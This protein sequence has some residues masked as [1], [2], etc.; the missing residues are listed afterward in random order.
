MISA[1]AEA[2]LRQRFE[3][4]LPHRLERIRNLKYQRIIGAHHFAVASRECLELY[5]DGYMLGCIMCAQSLLEAMLKFVAKRNELPHKKEVEDLIADLATAAI[6]SAE[7]ISS[8]RVSWRHRNDVH[9]LNHS[10]TSLDLTAKAKECVEATCA[11]EEDIF[12]A[13]VQ[14][15]ALVPH[16]PKYWDIGVSGT[17]PVFLRQ[18][19]V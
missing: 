9:H 4:Q 12:G 7:A 2:S 15:G 18:L 19:D 5:R 10:I 6:L 1:N 11:V 16:K 8:A 14:D 13:S 3:S 17:V